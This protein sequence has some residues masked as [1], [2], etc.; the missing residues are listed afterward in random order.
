LNNRYK[1][2]AIS[3]LRDM[4]V[5][6]SKRQMLLTES[7]LRTKWMN[8]KD[9]RKGNRARVFLYLV[10]IKY[11]LHFRNLIFYYFQKIN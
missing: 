5:L 10:Q 6:I 8:E 1:K 3:Y 2:K 9:G 4:F 7:E 11:I